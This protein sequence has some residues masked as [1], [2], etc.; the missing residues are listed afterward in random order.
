MGG[1]A[2]SLTVDHGI[3]RASGCGFGEIAR[4]LRF[5]RARTGLR[6]DACHLDAE[7]IRESLCRE[8]AFLCLTACSIAA[9]SAS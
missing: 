5:S 8:C 6:F 7:F 1:F 3:R 4:R 9:R 2:L